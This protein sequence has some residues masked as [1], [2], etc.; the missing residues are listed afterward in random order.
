MSDNGLQKESIKNFLLGIKYGLC[1]L[2][3]HRSTILFMKHGITSC[4][5]CLEIIC[6]VLEKALKP[7][8]PADLKP[9]Y[10]E[11]VS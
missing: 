5:G 6:F 4:K 3:G 2:C 7:I 10:S 11:V 9:L 8:S 1:P